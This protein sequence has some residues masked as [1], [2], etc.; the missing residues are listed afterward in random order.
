VAFLLPAM[1]QNTVSVHRLY[2]GWNAEPVSGTVSVQELLAQ[3]K[4][5]TGVVTVQQLRSEN[6]AASLPVDI[7]S[8]LPRMSPELA[9]AAYLNRAEHP[10]ARIGA[11]TSDTT[12]E[13]DLPD[14]QQH[15]EYQLQRTY[16]A[17]N[18]LKFKAVRFEGDGSV[19][20][21]VIGRLLTS[22]VQHVEKND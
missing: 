6:P 18:V 11:F 13:A 22:E 9:L 17:P 5:V 2:S 12:I 3:S 14:A 16:S 4:P 7:A 1:A 8:P 20:T 15:G 10:S 19:K 21:N